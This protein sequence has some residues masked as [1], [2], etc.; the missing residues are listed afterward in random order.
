MFHLNLFLSSYKATL[1][2]KPGSL[3]LE[4]GGVQ[5]CEYDDDSHHTLFQAVDKH[6]CEK[7][8]FLT[9]TPM[10]HNI[11]QIVA[12]LGQWGGS[13]VNRF[14]S[15]KKEL[16]D[17]IEKVIDAEAPR[18][19]IGTYIALGEDMAILERYSAL[20]FPTE[21]TARKYFYTQSG[22]SLSDKADLKGR[23]I[24]SPATPD[25]GNGYNIIVQRINDLLEMP[26]DIRNI[27]PDLRD[28]REAEDTDLLSPDPDITSA[29]EMILSNW[30]DRGFR[31]RKL[32]SDKFGQ[33]LDDTIWKSL[34]Q[35]A[36]I[37]E[38]VQVVADQL[39]R[40]KEEIAR[41][42][43]DVEPGPRGAVE[44]L[45]N[46]RDRLLQKINGKYVRKDCILN[47]KKT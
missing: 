13:A 17:E 6:F 1:N 27:D 39:E 32:L 29:V 38:L 18:I 2:I 10:Q 42:Y 35:E 11:K 19:D 45:S 44:Y 25:A 41:D 23:L 5:V 9:R 40:R 34:P 43:K 12:D 28:E 21:Q 46:R 37:K 4:I 15:L 7:F 8:Q 30:G 24:I 20:E 22:I 26:G 36:D 16:E 33:Q 3:S 14:R 31:E 47:R